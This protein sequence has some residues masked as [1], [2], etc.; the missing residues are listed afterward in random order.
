MFEYGQQQVQQQQQEQKLKEYPCTCGLGLDV[1]DLACP[2][3]SGMMKLWSALI[4]QLKIFPFFTLE[5]LEV[6]KCSFP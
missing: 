3:G 1:S 2:A 4:H 5:Y 6:F